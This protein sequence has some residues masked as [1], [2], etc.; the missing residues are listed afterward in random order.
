L[1][2]VTQSGV[3]FFGESLKAVTPLGEEFIF[4]PSPVRFRSHL[5]Y[6]S[7]SYTILST[8][9]LFPKKFD[10]FVREI[11]NLRGS[12]MKGPKPL[13]IVIKLGEC[14]NFISYLHNN[15]VIQILMT[16]NI[17]TS[18][19]VDEKTHEPLLPTLSLIVATAVQLH[20]DGHKVIIVS[21]GAIGVGLRRMDIERRPKHLPRVQVRIF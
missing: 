10:K 16:R 8:T 1:L 19:I 4:L 17:G 5:F 3:D 18:S 21:S 7:Q 14:S 6:K 12:K 15:F 13:T 2:G 11:G 20:K 9:S